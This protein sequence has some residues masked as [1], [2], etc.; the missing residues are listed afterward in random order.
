[1]W[2]QTRKCYVEGLRPHGGQLPSQWPSQTTAPMEPE[3]RTSLN[4]SSLAPVMGLLLIRCSPDEPG[5]EVSVYNLTN[6]DENAAINVFN[7]ASW[8]LTRDGAYGLWHCL[9]VLLPYELN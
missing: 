8:N 7:I 6:K 9:S 2:H 4:C 5:L 1:M 3:Q